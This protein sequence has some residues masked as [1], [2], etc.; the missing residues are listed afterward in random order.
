MPAAVVG[1]TIKPTRLRDKA[2]RLELLNAMRKF[3][4]SYMLPEF[5]KTTA[6]WD[7]KVDFEMLIS[8]TS[9]SFE[10]LVGTDNKIYRYVNDGTS[11]RHAVMSRDFKAK[12]TPRVIGS[13]PGAGG[14][15]FV[16]KKIKL[17]G[18]EA[19]HFDEEIQ[20]KS[21]KPYR[22]AMEAGMKRARQVSGHAI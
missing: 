1:K 8:T 4:N 9:G 20:K 5:K 12:T 15:V 17:P 6:T 10:V 3:G 13:V 11:V 7:T 2:M 18:I 21:L 19:R 16:S 14:V 22:R